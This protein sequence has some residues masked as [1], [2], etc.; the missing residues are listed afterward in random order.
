MGASERVPR[1]PL[2]SVRPPSPLC[3]LLFPSRRRSCEE[4]ESGKEG[5]K[6]EGG[7]GSGGWERGGGGALSVPDK[8]A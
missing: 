3:L 4:V 1:S 7:A 8:D 5:R 6:E 2:S